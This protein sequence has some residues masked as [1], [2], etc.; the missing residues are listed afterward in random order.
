ME[1]N[2]NY[3]AILTADVR[4]DKR[5]KANEKL[6]YA[7]ITALSNKNGYCNARNSYFAE[8]Y[9]R[10]KDTI[11]EW[12]NNLKKYGYITVE[13]I[14]RE[15]KTA[16]RRICIVKTPGQIG[17][18]TYRGIG[19]NAEGG[20]GKNTEQNNTSIEYKE[21]EKEINKEKVKQENFNE[22]MPEENTESV[23][24]YYNNNITLISPTVAEEI[25]YYLDDGL[26]EGL[27]KR[28]I[29]EAVDQNARKWKYIKTILDNCKKD[30]IR[31]VEEFEINQKEF[32]EK[33]KKKADK[34][35]FKEKP[36]QEVKYNTDFSEYDKYIRG[37]D[38]SG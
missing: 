30:N 5:L 17:K 37:D 8:L 23:I 9:D 6:L 11:S 18:N 15:G 34:Q 38:K 22:T 33:Q 29:K 14:N 26:T 16:E 13:L 10:H 19:E 36:K 2:S 1:S 12:I 27:I 32:R 28:C 21:E 3:Y 20:I 4:Y 35:T 31:T 25:N 7:E 24:D